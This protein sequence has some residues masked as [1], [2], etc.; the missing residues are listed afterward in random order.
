M[1]LEVSS[2]FNLPTSI[3]ALPSINNGNPLLSNILEV[4][5]MRNC[6]GENFAQGPIKFQWAIPSNER[7]KMDESYFRVRMSLWSSNATGTAW[8]APTKS[9]KS[10]FAQGG[11]G[12]TANNFL[13]RACPDSELQVPISGD[14]VA[15]C[16]NPVASL[17]NMINF[18]VGGQIVSEVQSYQPQIDTAVRRLTESF[19]SQTASKWRDLF[20][21]TLRERID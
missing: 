13:T 2:Q 19:V 8:V 16:E 12:N 1:S 17:F 9:F 15:F 18:K 14:D 11:L 20:G 3:N 21:T 4:N 10:Y 6:L 5:P 7:G